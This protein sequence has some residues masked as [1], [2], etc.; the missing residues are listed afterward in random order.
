MTEII[1]PAQTRVV[2]QEWADR[3]VAPMVD[4]RVQAQEGHDADPPASAYQD[5]V[6]ALYVYRMRR[7]S[8]VYDGVVADV[9]LDAFA[10][11]RVRGHES[12]QPHRVEL[13]V[14]YYAG[15]P[16]RS[17]PVALLHAED[18]TATRLV[19]ETCSGRPLVQFEG[20]D[21]LEH[22]VW[23]IDGADETAELAAALGGEVL[24]IAD[25]HHRVAARLTAWERAGRPADAGVLCVLYPMGGLRL[26]AFHRRVAGPVDAAALL[27]SA[28]A[29]FVVRA[30][31]AGGEV[32]GIGL[33]LDG[34][35]YDLTPA[36]ARPGGSAGLDV[37]VLHSR[38][39]GPVLG[40][41]GAVHPRLD[42]VP[43]HLPLEDAVSRCA[44]DDGALFCLRPPAL[45]KVTEIADLG[46]VTPPKTTYF[47]PKPYAG[48]FL[49]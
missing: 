22:L 1:R 39:L 33:Y 20:P 43:A 32:D 34:S 4:A 15:L 37:S 25:G 45:E 44:E 21:G 35:W 47:S 30:V 24:Y 46:E 13:L 26:G 16:S 14:E 19:K 11:G 7:G 23:R 18:A 3:A 48:I 42:L 36:G 29:D 9:R 31:P 10:D 41:A 40:I 38:I 12:V 27:A 28:E 2:R 6:R 17:E 49:I 8:E 5:S